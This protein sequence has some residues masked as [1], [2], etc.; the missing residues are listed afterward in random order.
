MSKPAAKKTPA[1]APVLGLTAPKGF[2]AAGLAAGIKKS[3][4]KDLML[5]V[6]DRPCSA[7]GVFTTSLTP[8]EPIFVTQKHLKD[9]AIRAIIVN[10]GCANA[11][12]G[13]AGKKDALKMCELVAE[14]AGLKAGEVLVASTGI[15]G[16]PLPMDKIEAG[17]RVAVKKLADGQTADAES[18]E[19][20]MTTDLVAK[21]AHRT[22]NI[23]NKTVTLAGI[24]KGS[25]M[26]A[27][28]MA[29]MLG[30]I[31]CDA[32]IPAAALSKSLKE[33][34]TAT[35]NRISVDQHTS[36]SDAV[37]ILCNG[38]A[39]NAPVKP[40][41]AD[42]AAFTAALTDL[43][44]E[45]AEKI[46]RDGEGATK[47]FRVKISGAKDEADADLIGRSIVNSPLVKCAVHGGD[48]N[49]GRITTAAGCSGAKGVHPGS[50]RLDISEL[51]KPAITVYKAGAPVRLSVPERKR[52][53]SAMKAKDIVLHLQM[54]MG[55]AE[56]EWMGCDLSAEYVRIN[57]EYTT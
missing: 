2:K 4:K 22:V 26:I 54:G 33:A 39:E 17:I 14:E 25:G 53:E 9:G 15:I 41:G 55:K 36:C 37:L 27:P 32:A 16:V 28:N 51:G 31:T 21:L 43:C 1:A 5:V 40:G 57:A 48:P 20:I 10:A 7:A 3:G 35:F 46:V 45:M 19:A 30:F 13:E 29:T 47:V 34:A 24:C 6:S 38:A 56:V 49:W 52:L 11:S 12:T 8:A 50:M 18:A 23:G 44:K 42:H